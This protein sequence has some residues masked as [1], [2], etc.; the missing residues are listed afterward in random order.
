MWNET[1]AEIIARDLVRLNRLLNESHELF[2]EFVDEFIE[3]NRN[4]E[5]TDEEIVQGLIQCMNGKRDIVPR[6]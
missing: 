3:E 6:G 2:G 4:N 5:W 1:D